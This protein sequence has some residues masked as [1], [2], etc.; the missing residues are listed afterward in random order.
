MSFS[1]GPNQYGKAGVRLVTVDGP[2]VTDLTIASALS[3]DLAATHLTGDNSAVLATDTQKNTMYAFAREYGVGSPEA[4][5]VLLGK[6][7]LSSEIHRAQ[8]TIE[9]HRWEQFG[10]HSFRRSGGET[11]LARVVVTADSVAVS[12]GLSGLTVLNTTASE[13]HGFPR[14][15]YTTL[16]ETT[17]RML[18]TSVDA[19][20][21]HSDPSLDWDAAFSDARGALLTAFSSTY[22][23]SLQQTLFSMGSYLLAQCPSVGEVRLSLPNKHHNLVDLTPFGLDNPNQV[24]VAPT[25]PFGLIQGT[26]RRDGATYTEGPALW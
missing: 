1:L 8:L 24:Y 23:Y 19:W 4:F 15:E 6:H 9:Q 25:E 2:V 22:S 18:A 13:F 14:D 26:V 21:D 5:G 12:S 10:P 17:D 3:G 20:W 11:R 16:P 7:F